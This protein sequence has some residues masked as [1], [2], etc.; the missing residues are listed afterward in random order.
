MK[1]K[2]AGINYD[3]T[4]F[5]KEKN[6]NDLLEMT[7]EAAKNDAKLIALPEMGT[8][9]YCWYRREE[10]RNEVEPI[11]GPTTEKFSKIAKE[12]DC[13]IVVGMPEVDEKTDLY[14]NSAVLIGPE[15]VIGVHRKSHLYISEPKWAKQGDVGHQVFETPIGNLGML[16]CMDIHFVE[17]ARLEGLGNADVIIHLSNW[18]AEKTPAPYWLTR[19][20]ENG[21]YVLESNRCGLERTVQASGGSVLINPDGTINSYVDDGNQIMYGEVDLEQARKKDFD[22]TGNKFLERRPDEYKELLQDPYLWNPLEFFGLYGYDPLPK[23]KKSNITVAQSQF[24]LGDIEKNL[25]KIKALAEDAADR[26]S[27]L[28]VFPELSLCV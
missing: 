15:G 23:G 7:E 24:S 14:Y 26:Q 2:V 21:C 10:I 18:L 12:Y 9:G 4:M 17:T 5:M 13:Y 6:V 25:Q 8:T 3:P 11:P 20:F 28:I 16:I 22:G 1:Y 27:E 19:G